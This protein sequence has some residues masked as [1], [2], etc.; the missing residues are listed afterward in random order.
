MLTR[1]NVN[2]ALLEKTHFRI[3]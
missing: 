1:G 3:H 2:F